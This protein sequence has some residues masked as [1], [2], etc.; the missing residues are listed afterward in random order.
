MRPEFRD[1]A[2]S[3]LHARG[4]GQGGTRPTLDQVPTKS[5]ARGRAMKGAAGQRVRRLVEDCPPARPVAT[6][7]PAT[8]HAQTNI[9]GR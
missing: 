9:H 3:V 5:C 7:N 4:G 1:L 2:P 6:L 8:T